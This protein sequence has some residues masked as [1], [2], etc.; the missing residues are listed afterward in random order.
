MGVHE[1]NVRALQIYEQLGYTILLTN[2]EER[3]SLFE[4]FITYRYQG[5]TAILFKH[6]RIGTV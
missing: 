2:H 3:T 5:E 1:S 6:L 4:G